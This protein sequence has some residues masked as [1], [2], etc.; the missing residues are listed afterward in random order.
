MLDLFN[1]INE[2]G[3]QISIRVVTKASSNK[4]KIEYQLDGSKLYRVY[5]TAVAENGKANNAILKLLSHELGIPKSSL[6]IIMG[7]KSRDKI[8]EIIK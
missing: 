1:S 3:K 5:V 8:I 2:I 4:V 7:H 6:S